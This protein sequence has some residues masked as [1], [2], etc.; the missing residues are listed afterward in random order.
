MAKRDEELPPIPMGLQKLLRRAATDAECY[1]RVL[2]LRGEAAADEGI[3]FNAREKAMLGAV[4]EA[5]LRGMI[6]ALRPAPGR[7]GFLQQAV[8]LGGV[9]L[10]LS[11]CEER[12]PVLTAGV[13]PDVPPTTT[14]EVV[15]SPSRSDEAPPPP[16][17][18]R[19]DVPPERPE[20][21]GMHTKG[22]AEPS[23]PEE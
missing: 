5:Q 22:G 20:H 15:P 7:R 12:S 1:A 23:I 8:L 10:G 19:P 4:T 2:A 17:G 13:R 11:G 21:P 6:E 14:P 16:A 18:I 9:T 3:E